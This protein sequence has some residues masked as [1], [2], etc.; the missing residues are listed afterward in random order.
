MERLQISLQQ[1]RFV[2]K[3]YLD[4]WKQFVPVLFDLE[5]SITRLCFDTA[6]RQF[7]QMRPCF[8]PFS[9]RID[10][11]LL[12]FNQLWSQE[13]LS[14]NE[15]ST[16]SLILLNL[17]N[18][19]VSDVEQIRCSTSPDNRNEFFIML[20]S[21]P[22]PCPGCGCHTPRIKNYVSKKSPMMLWPVRIPIYSIMPDV[23]SV[24][25]VP[26]PIMNTILLCSVP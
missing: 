15:I 13:V 23:M 14:M 22:I 3:R 17:F 9:H 4:Y 24:P 11:F 10:T 6:S 12:L 25:F 20:A 16:D 18:L 1:I 5:D 2:R 26:E 19:S 21:H 8:F 7:L